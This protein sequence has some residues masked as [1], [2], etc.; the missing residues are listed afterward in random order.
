MAHFSKLCEFA[1]PLWGRCDLNRGRAPAAIPYPSAHRAEKGHP[2]LEPRPAS[3]R[4]T[5]VR[6]AIT[7]RGATAMCSATTVALPPVRSD[8][9]AGAVDRG[10]QRESRSRVFAR[11][12]RMVRSLSR[13]AVRSGLIGG[14]VELPGGETRA[15][16][17]VCGALPGRP[18]H[19]REPGA[20]R[21]G[22]VRQGPAR[23]LAIVE[24]V[25]PFFAGGVL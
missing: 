14:S 25:D 18:A 11:C 6:S 2:P 21:R 10:R 1:R 17:P 12:S 24:R 7:M 13:L 20:L 4:W 19:Q 5:A 8:R 15:A 9:P 22:R 23:R 16:P 3:R